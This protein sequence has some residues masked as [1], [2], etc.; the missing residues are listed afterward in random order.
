MTRFHKWLRPRCA[1]PWWSQPLR[2]STASAIL[3]AAVFVGSA[4]T[5]V[6]AAGVVGTGT[7]ASCTEV[8]LNGALAGGGLVTFKCGGGPVTITV[9]GEKT[10]SVNTTLDGGGTVTLSGGDLVRVLSVEFGATVDL[11]NLTIQHGRAPNCPGAPPGVEGLTRCGGGVFNLGA[12]TVTNSTITTN[13]AQ[14][15]GGILNG[16]LLAVVTSVVSDNR[17]DMGGGG[18]FNFNGVVAL[19]QS[20]VARN[21]AAQGFGGGLGNASASALPATIT[22]TDGTFSNNRAVSGGGIANGFCTAGFCVSGAVVIAGTV[23]TDNVADSAGGGILNFGTLALSDS[24]FTGNSAVVGGGGIYNWW[25]ATATVSN[26]A[27]SRNRCTQGGPYGSGGAIYTAATLS[28]TASRFA[29]NDAPGGGAINSEGTGGILSVTASSF[30]GNTARTGGAVAHAGTGQSSLVSHCTFTRN[31]ADAGGG[32]WVF[33]SL[34]V[35]DCA[36]SD[37][38]ATVGGAI[39]SSGLLDV[40]NSTL[41]NNAASQ[42]GGAIDNSVGDLTLVNSTVSGNTAG[43]DG[44]GIHDLGSV[45]VVAT[46]VSGNVAAARGGGLFGWGTVMLSNSTFV[47]NEAQE[48]G[49]VVHFR[50]APCSVINSTIAQ[51]TAPGSAGVVSDEGTIDLANSIL[52]NGASGDCVTKNGGVALGGHNLIADATSA[53]GLVNGVDG[54]LVG[55]DPMLETLADN[56]GPTQTI[57]VRAGSPAIDA[58][59][60]LVCTRPPVNNVDQRGYTRPGTASINCAI[61]AYEYDSLGPPPVCLGD[62]N[63]DVQVTIDDLITE[64]NVALGWQKAWVCS[65][66]DANGD[67]QITVDEILVAVNHALSGCGAT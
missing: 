46:T 27:F 9:T 10:L 48:G 38:Q 8:A 11:R 43:E 29:D 36:F 34:T 59:D 16:G 3:S 62:C 45:T 33:T 37:N 58:G 22:V 24:S 55:V 35:A 49:G 1:A 4:P 61:G 54:N 65:R 21:Q 30:T 40:V 7:A 2:L 56:G 5:A 19:T 47:G 42:T 12:L 50:S 26:T 66:G 23:L 25:G 39:A 63:G 60:A 31:R 64:V 57:A 44:G 28:V 17:A 20:T 41:T 32:L 51:N 15:G 52:A 13:D 67:R 53:C 18:I 14:L 6:W